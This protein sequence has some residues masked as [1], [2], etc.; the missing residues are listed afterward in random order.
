MELMLHSNC[1]YQCWIQLR[2]QA[3][4]CIF[5]PPPSPVTAG[6]PVQ[7]NLGELHALMEF[8]TPG[9]LGTAKD[10]KEAYEKPINAGQDRCGGCK[11]SGHS[12]ACMQIARCV[13]VWVGNKGD[14]CAIGMCT[15]ASPH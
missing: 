12:K 6:T 7:N 9:L 5:T 3:L 4:A 14:L 11:H 13:S 1:T 8:A 2:P 15:A 10:F